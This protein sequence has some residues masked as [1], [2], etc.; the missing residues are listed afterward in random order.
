MVRLKVLRSIRGKLFLYF[1]MIVIF[2]SLITGIIQYNINNKR[3]LEDIRVEVSR[4]ASASSLII[5]GDLHEK[6]KSIDD[7]S[8][9]IYKDLRTRMINFKKETGIKGIYTMVEKGKDKTAFIIDSDE[10]SKTAI[11]YEYDYLPEM[12]SAFEG[13]ASADKEM[14]TDEWGTVISGYAPIKNSNGKVIAII[15]VDIDSSKIL[16]ARSQLIASISINMVFSI[17]LA[18]ILSSLLASKITNPIYLL[19]KRFKEISSSGDLNQ[20]IEIKTGDELETL[21]NEVND[22]IKSIKSI[23]EEI[24]GA[25]DRVASSSE[26]LN[27]TINQNKKSV[28]EVACAIENIALGATKQSESVNNISSGIQEIAKDIDEN[29]KNI[30]IIN[31]SVDKTK[32]LINSGLEAVNN[33]SIKTEENLVAFNKVTEVVGK[34]AKEVA[35]VEEILSTITNI[36]E[37]TNLL[38][39]NAAIEAARAGEHGKGFSVVAEEV[40]K[41]A[42][43]ASVA[44]NEIGEILKR[45]TM[46]TKLSI[47][48]IKCADLIA[49]EQKIAVDSTGITFSDMTKEIESMFQRI[50]IISVSF[51]GIGDN[52]NTIVDKIQGISSVAEENVAIT[53]E[54]LAIS[55]EQNSSMEEIKSVT[56]NLNQLSNKL[57]GIISKFKI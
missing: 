54:V 24:T 16:E 51:K 15:G 7:Q 42:E 35:K 22:F 19:G 4:L 12:K 6:L 30:D 26:D 43:E 34:L 56:N 52:T 44:T 28:E 32:N 9:D 33:Q 36:S 27:N 50:Q 57:Q 25:A 31:K 49:K 18:L 17:I 20:R 14:Y 13:I 46:D 41:L 1:G 39:L 37:Q 2:I 11:G 48:E 47:D 55:E 8:S 23:V 21:G 10:E 29:K 45:I 5:D 40:R 3:L 53:E 38:A